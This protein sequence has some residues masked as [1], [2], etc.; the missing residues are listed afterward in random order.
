MAAGSSDH[1]GL[2]LSKQVRA[3]VSSCLHHLR[4][5]KVR[6]HQQC[7]VPNGQYSA[8]ST[9]DLQ[10][11]LGN[12]FLCSLQRHPLSPSLESRPCLTR[13]EGAFRE[14]PQV[15]NLRLRQSLRRSS[16]Q[17]EQR[18]GVIGVISLGIFVVNVEQ[19]Y[20]L[21]LLMMMCSRIQKNNKI[22]LSTKLLNK[23]LWSLR[24]GNQMLTISTS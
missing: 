20:K 16:R 4:N 11:P 3:A 2:D 21:Q 23:L 19:F 8:L 7:Q 13:L 15:V 12:Q 24:F 18:S 17:E 5:N 6:P 1:G 14:M 10:L 9:T 22:F